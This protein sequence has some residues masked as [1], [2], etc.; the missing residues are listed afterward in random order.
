MPCAKII[1]IH[2]I[3]KEISIT[4]LTMKVL[5]KSKCEYIENLE[6]ENAFLRYNIS[7]HKEKDL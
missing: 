5:V 7:I 1:K 6:V 3:I 2:M 4:F